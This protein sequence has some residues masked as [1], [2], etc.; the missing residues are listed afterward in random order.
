MSF[1][2]GITFRI[3]ILNAAV[4]F[5][6]CVLEAALVGLSWWR[7]SRPRQSIAEPQI[8]CCWIGFR[9]TTGDPQ[10]SRTESCFVSLFSAVL[11]SSV[12]LD[13]N[14]PHLSPESCPWWR[15]TPAPCTLSYFSPEMVYSCELE[16]PNANPI[17]MQVRY[18]FMLPA[19]VTRYTE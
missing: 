9:R 7:R 2:R 18:L 14:W 6:K 1:S 13:L 8:F 3:H 4:E 11:C 19:S 16:A 15:L 5:F 10:V 17:K 12:A